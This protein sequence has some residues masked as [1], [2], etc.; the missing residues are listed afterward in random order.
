MRLPKL[1][2]TGPALTNP[3]LAEPAPPSSSNFGG[4]G[5]GIISSKTR[6]EYI[7]GGILDQSY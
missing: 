3:A 7:L 6:T 1:E 5:C 4:S 2:L